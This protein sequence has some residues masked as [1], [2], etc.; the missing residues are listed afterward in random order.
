MSHHTRKSVCFHIY[1]GDEKFIIKCIRVLWHKHLLRG[2]LVRI[3]KNSFIYKKKLS[4]SDFIISR[5][6]LYSYADQL[7]DLI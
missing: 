2:D 3:G 6:E 1:N 5:R 7:I 4:R